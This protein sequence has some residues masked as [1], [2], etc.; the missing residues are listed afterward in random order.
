MTDTRTF[1]TVTAVHEPLRGPRPW[2]EAALT[3]LSEVGDLLDR[4]E[5]AG[6]ETRRVDVEGGEYIVR[7]R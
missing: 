6:Y 4:L 3:D 7:W 2:R 1:P 5:T